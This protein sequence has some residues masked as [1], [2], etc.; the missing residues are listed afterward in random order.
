LA[1]LVAELKLKLVQN[2]EGKLSQGTR[3]A[4]RKQA[5]VDFQATSSSSAAQAT[6]ASSS[7]SST[8]APAPA[9][10]ALLPPLVELSIVLLEERLKPFDSAVR[11]SLY[12]LLPPLRDLRQGLAGLYPLQCD[13][14]FVSL[15]LADMLGDA[16]LRVL[17][18][19]NLRDD[20]AG[21]LLAA[22]LSAR[23]C[24]W[25]NLRNLHGL[26]LMATARAGL[27]P[28]ASKSRL[29]YDGG[30]ATSVQQQ[31]LQGGKS[32]GAAGCIPGSH[33]APAAV[34][35]DGP[36][37]V[38]SS[39]PPLRA[40]PAPSSPPP[41]LL[42]AQHAASAAFSAVAVTSSSSPRQQA[43]AVLS[44]SVN[45][46]PTTLLSPQ[47]GEHL[48][49]ADAA[50]SSATPISP[51]PLL[52]QAASTNGLQHSPRMSPVSE[53]DLHRRIH[54]GPAAHVSNSSINSAG[55]SAH[56]HG[57]HSPDSYLAS[58]R[59]PSLSHSE[60]SVSGY[61]STVAAAEDTAV[62]P[63]AASS[64]IPVP[65][66]AVAP[67]RRDS[68][69]VGESQL[70]EY[71]LP[72]APVAPLHHHQ[73]TPVSEQHT[74]PLNASL[75]TTS[76]HSNEHRSSSP[77]RSRTH[78]LSP[79]SSSL[80]S[81]PSPAAAAA[82]LHSARAAASAHHPRQPLQPGEWSEHVH[83]ESGQTFWH[84][85]R[86]GVS[87]WVKPLAAASE[88][89]AAKLTALA[90]D[91]ADSYGVA[92]TTA[93]V[94]AGGAAKSSAARNSDGEEEEVETVLS[95]TAVQPVVLGFAAAATPKPCAFAGCHKTRF[96][97][98]PYCVHHLAVNA[99]Q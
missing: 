83:A 20:M 99:Q 72:P 10:A 46:G 31:P 45:G 49:V 87:S 32:Y 90:T 22:F 50:A 85:A 28:Q 79:H 33:M 73:L 80:Q 54:S 82:A 15:V 60:R 3:A 52:L 62:A 37:Y 66:T 38:S 16:Y 57:L 86:T 61:A 8:C 35:R 65:S 98:K 23:T 14:A 93:T 26:D 41:P 43:P 29:F 34:A 78:S 95:T 91:D 6:S 9:T 67:T 96:A 59:R 25:V 56:D 40:A 47:G 24:A 58:H 89:F 27:A 44:V 69:S 5:S 19:A 30:V 68:D 51:P 92:A 63:A 76:P 71:D 13:D 75:D 94:A 48:Q 53:M 18:N 70:D 12:A 1:T 2:I 4:L 55:G 74:S 64:A 97:A 21:P 88:G 42:S 17:Q 81:E 39:S 7:A 11:E 36:T 84:N 77:R